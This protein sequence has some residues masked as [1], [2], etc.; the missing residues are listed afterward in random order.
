MATL[1]I[2]CEPL[3][4]VQAH[5]A[6]LGHSKHAEVGTAP[7]T[8]MVL[9]RSAPVAMDPVLLAQRVGQN[10]FNHVRFEL[11]CCLETPLT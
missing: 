4:A 9:A 6:A 2:L 8:E 5:V 11:P 3:E 1:G 7:S 10:L